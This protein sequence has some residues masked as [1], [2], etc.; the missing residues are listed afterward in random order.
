MRVFI[1]VVSS[2]LCI[3]ASLRGQLNIAV[4]TRVVVV[5]MAGDTTRISF[6]VANSP[7]SQERLFRFLVDAPAPVVRIVTPSPQELWAARTRSKGISV[8]SWGILGPIVPPGT[9]SPV[10]SFE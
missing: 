9:T 6:T 10:L 3:A 8:A 4:D 2:G 1:A 5:Q 7:T